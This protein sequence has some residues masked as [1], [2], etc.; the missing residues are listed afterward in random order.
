MKIYVVVDDRDSDNFLWYYSM[1]KTRAETY[2]H[3]LMRK[4]FLEGWTQTEE[5]YE[6]HE[7]RS[8][9]DLKNIQFPS[10]DF[11]SE[12][13]TGIGHESYFCQ[14][15]IDAWS[16]EFSTDETKWHTDDNTFYEVKMFEDEDHPRYFKTIDEVIRFID[17]AYFEEYGDVFKEIEGYPFPDEINYEEYGKHIFEE[18]IV[19]KYVFEKPMNY[20]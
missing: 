2:M 11:V 8:E 17:E 5:G 18:S 20:K 4:A 13:C 12:Q 15:I 19:F 7:K 3:N 16:I 1:D 9:E 14:D 6:L 10:F